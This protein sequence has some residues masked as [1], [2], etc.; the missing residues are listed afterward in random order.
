VGKGISSIKG[1]QFPASLKG[2]REKHKRPRSQVFGIHLR[3]LEIKLRKRR[4]RFRANGDTASKR[5]VKRMAD[6]GNVE[7]RCPNESRTNA[8]C[9]NGV[10]GF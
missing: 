4:N 10:Y 9:S 6:Q 7:K 2:L 1:V 3:I 8:C 5:G